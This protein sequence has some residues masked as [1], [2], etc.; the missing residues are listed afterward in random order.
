M[1]IDF[2][3]NLVFD[4]RIEIVG[5]EV[6]LAA[7]EKTG[8][9]LQDRFDKS[10]EQYSLADEALKQMEASANPVDRDKAKE[11]RG[12]YSQEMQGILQKGD[13]HNMRHQV[14]ALARNAAANYK[15]IAERNQIIQQNIDAIKKDPRYQLDPEGAVNHYLKDLKSININPET[16]TVSD[17]NVGTYGAAPDVDV[18]KFLLQV[19][20]TLR[21]KTKRGKDAKFATRTF[22][23]NTYIVKET[24][25]G[26]VEILSKEEI[27]S[28]LG[29]Y[30]KA[31]QGIMNYLIRDVGRAGLDVN[32]KEGQQYLNELF[33][34][35]VTKAATAVA[36]MYDVYKDSRRKDFQ[37][38]GEQK[39]KGFG[40]PNDPYAGTYSPNDVFQ[41]YKTQ[42]KLEFPD[43]LNSALQDNKRS[44]ATLLSS[45]DYMAQNGNTTAIEAKKIVKGLTEFTKKYPEYA[46]IIRRNTGGQ[47]NIPFGHLGQAFLNLGSLIYNRAT[48]TKERYE[49]AA[50]EADK[51]IKQYKTLADR[52]ILDSK[53]ENE[54]EAATATAPMVRKLPIVTPNLESTEVRE[55]L[56]KLS[57]DLNINKFDIVEGEWKDKDKSKIK[58]SGYTLEPYGSGTGIAF[59]LMDE[60]G[61]TVIATPNKVAEKDVAREMARISPF[62]YSSM[63]YKDMTPLSYPNQIK[64]FEDIS[65]ETGINLPKGYKI[66]MLEDGTYVRINPNGKTDAKAQSPY[67]LLPV[68]K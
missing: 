63:M 26:Q 10:Y 64:T 60:D 58:I 54:F 59:E 43:L 50:T 39:S 68:K 49:A 7:M 1:S 36:P 14:S 56:N 66:Q 24:E 47:T 42:G 38:I 65:E 29:N 6:P 13:F 40:N 3:K 31:D 37:V 67:L 41:D 18:A 55:A 22:D 5:N 45:L 44:Q 32:S 33:N 11:L 25:D 51:L 28:E 27:A 8:S 46:G 15:T 34:S 61:N 30:A 53:F 2:S 20:P 23:G 21:T 12:L 19:A 9:V 35:R 17:F 16:R 57:T 52:G 48:G 4:P 62:I